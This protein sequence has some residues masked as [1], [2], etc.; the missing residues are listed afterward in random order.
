MADEVRWEPTKDQSQTKR[1]E[2]EVIELGTGQSVHGGFR[3]IKVKASDGTVWSVAAFHS[4]LKRQV[5]EAG[6]TPGD[7]IVVE[8][9]GMQKSKNDRDFHNYQ[10]DLLNKTEA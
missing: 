10:L 3:T 5:E 8:Y 6:L 2:G 4:V 1:I 7:A 9:L